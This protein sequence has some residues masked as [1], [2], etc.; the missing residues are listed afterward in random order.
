A[1]IN[2]GNSGGPLVNLEGE[3]VGINVAIRAGAQRIGGIGFAIPANMARNIMQSLIHDGRVVRGWLGVSVQELSPELA[4]SFGYK[5][6]E[7]VLVGEVLADGPARKAGLTD[8]D[9]IVTVDGRPI[10]SPTTLRNVIAAITPGN[11]ARFDVFREGHNQNIDVR[12]GQL[13]DQKSAS[14]SEEQDSDLGM[15]VTNLTPAL[16]KQLEI[17]ESEGVVVESIET[18]GSAYR[19]GLRQGDV[20]TQV[21]K[22]VVSSVADFNRELARHDLIEGVRLTVRTGDAQHY[23]ILKS[24]AD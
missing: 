24:D 15:T 5:G 14:T 18:S 7:G 3:V 6:H 20:I 8:G 16:A 21:K 23:I 19:S 1:A 2:P 12:I 10:D 4:G 9:I 22:N 11:T 13:A 17:A